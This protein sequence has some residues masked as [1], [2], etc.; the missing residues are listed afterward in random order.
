[1]NA[2]FVEEE[3]GEGVVELEPNADEEGCDGED[4]HGAFLEQAE[5]FAVENS[6]V[7]GGAMFGE[8]RRCGKRDAVEAHQ[9][10]REGSDLR[11]LAVAS[12]RKSRR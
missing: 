12:S 8:R 6:V 11:G 5:G 4:G 1:M 3:V 9:Q 7:G 10:R 2:A